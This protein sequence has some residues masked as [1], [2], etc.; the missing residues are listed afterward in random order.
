VGDDTVRNKCPNCGSS[1]HYDQKLWLWR[2]GNCRRIYSARELSGEHSYE[3]GQDRR[4][5]QA[6]S[7][8]EVWYPRADSGI[9]SPP[10]DI[11]PEN[12]KN[13]REASSGS[14]LRNLFGTIGTLAFLFGLVVLVGSMVSI[15]WPQGVVKL[16]PKALEVLHV[17]PTSM[18][19]RWAEKTVFE[20]VNQKRMEAGLAPLA[21]DESIASYSRKH[22]ADMAEKGEVYH[23]VAELAD[24]RLGENAAMNPRAAGGFIL[25]P[26]PVGL[27]FYKTDRELLGETVESWMKSSGHRQNILNASYTSTG[28]GIA[29]AEDGVTHYL[30]QDFK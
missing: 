27:A 12:A 28:V 16:V 2:C 7:H 20:M 9:Y 17:L 19:L 21:W 10:D 4:T 11:A 14:G 22:S 8:G 26:Y 30:T 29:V 5:E 23:D 6:R 15:A 13:T 1:L 18:D 24:L 25:L 3:D